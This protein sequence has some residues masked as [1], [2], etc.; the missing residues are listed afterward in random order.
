MEALFLILLLP[1]IVFFHYRNLWVYQVRKRVL[2]ELGLKTYKQLAS[3][4]VM[5][6]KFWIWNWHRFLSSDK[7]RGE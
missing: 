6:F 3:Y 4:N 1:V 7:R 5:V 2:S